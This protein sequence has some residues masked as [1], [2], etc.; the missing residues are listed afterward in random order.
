MIPLVVFFHEF[1]LKTPRENGAGDYRVQAYNYRLCTTNAKGNVVPFEKPADYKP[2]QYG[3]LRRVFEGGPYSMF[4]GGKIPNMK[5]DVNNVWPFSS[6]IIGMNY[7][8]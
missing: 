2:E 8:C 4:G 5:R 6:N 7:E 1:L 3:L